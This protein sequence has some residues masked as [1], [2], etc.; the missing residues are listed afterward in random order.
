VIVKPRDLKEEGGSKIRLRFEPFAP[1]P[2]GIDE[3]GVEA[4]SRPRLGEAPRGSAE[5]GRVKMGL[6]AA[7]QDRVGQRITDDR[8]HCRGSTAPSS[9]SPSAGE[10]RD[11]P[12]VEEWG[13]NTDVAGQ[14]LQ[15]LR[16]HEN[17]TRAGGM[18]HDP[19]ESH[20]LVRSGSLDA[21]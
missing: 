15:T 8:S 16:R 21:P 6:I 4:T 2:V 18:R 1:K 3:A 9:G 14:P 13:L 12:W 17:G 7:P 20:G 5:V 19:I 11:E 10:G